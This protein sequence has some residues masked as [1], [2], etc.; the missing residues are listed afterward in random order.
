MA[1][2]A[3]LL[4]VLVVAVVAF[5]AP[6]QPA[7]A[8]E[9]ALSPNLA[10]NL[11]YI[12][13]GMT[14]GR[15]KAVSQFPGRSLNSS[16]ESQ[17][18]REKLTIDL[19]SAAPSID[20]ELSTSGFQVVLNLDDGNTLRIRRMPQGDG[21]TKY[22]EFHQPA[23]GPITV[24]IGQNPPEKTYSADS[25]WH[26]LVAEPEMARTEL[27]PLLRLM[28]PGW[29]LASEGQA[30]EQSLYKQVDV[31]R[32]Y[33]RQA[34]AELVNQLRAAN[35]ADRIEADRRLREL[36][37]VV[38]PYLRNLAVN[39]LDAEQA[40]RIRM[41]VRRYGAGADEDSPE[42]AASWLA[43]D[44]EIWLA[45]APRTTAAQRAKVRTQL[46]LILGEP[47]VFDADASGETLKAQLAKIREQINRLRES[48]SKT[49]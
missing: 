11:R 35:Y 22:L 39:R 7:P 40:Y 3:R 31:E 4:L 47:V 23:E 44:P 28:R 41:I 13:V 49:P 8:Q 12:H 6:S 9:I 17:D 20:Y 38:V 14:S 16:T 5:A 15:V 10:N 2:T 24:T 34:W 43:A 25:L 29:P 37:Q 36:G 42:T 32:N 27:E 19:N 45:L 26:L 1:R 33:D 21:K 18:R 48:Q 30:I 46:A